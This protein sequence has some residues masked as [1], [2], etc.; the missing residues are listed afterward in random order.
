MQ[1]EQSP[2][3]PGFPTHCNKEE[4]DRRK[5]QRLQEKLEGVLEEEEEEETGL[6]SEDEF[7]DQAN[8]FMSYRTGG[9]F[10]SSEKG[11]YLD[12]KYGGEVFGRVVDGMDQEGLRRV[13]ESLLNAQSRGE[14]K[15]FT[16]F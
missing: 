1:I 5:Q 11:S 4:Q 13:E 10:P 15:V 14:E 8:R 6:D 16:H 9:G 7:V 2:E 12:G 3:K